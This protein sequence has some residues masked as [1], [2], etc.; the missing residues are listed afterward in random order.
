MYSNGQHVYPPHMPPQDATLT[1]IS[2][3]A[4]AVAITLIQLYDAIR[5]AKANGYSYQELQTAT[6]IAR[7]TIQ[8]IVAGGNPRFTLQ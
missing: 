7:G 6:G 4:R 1:D 2:E 5:E 3:Q 8:N